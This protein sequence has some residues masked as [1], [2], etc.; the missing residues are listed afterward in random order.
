MVSWFFVKI[1]C[2]FLNTL[3]SI[4]PI[5]KWHMGLIFDVIWTGFPR[6]WRNCA[7]MHAALISR[8]FLHSITQIF[9]HFTFDHFGTIVFWWA[10]LLFGARSYRIWTQCLF[11]WL[12]SRTWLL[13]NKNWLIIYNIVI[14][15]I[16]ISEIMWCESKKNP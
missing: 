13:K 4:L 10:P 8:I 7:V 14:V 3:K 5:Q 12:L 1:K 15:R 11:P 16:I 6:G 2:F 9:G